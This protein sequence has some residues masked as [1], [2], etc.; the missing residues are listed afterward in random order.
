MRR[1]RRN[2]GGLPLKVTPV[3]KLPASLPTRQV[4]ERVVESAAAVRVVMRPRLPLP[5]P[6][7]KRVVEREGVNPVL[8]PPDRRAK[9]AKRDR[10]EV[11]HLLPDLDLGLRQ[12]EMKMASFHAM[13]LVAANAKRDRIALWTTVS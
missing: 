1:L 12:L 2:K 8:R 13:L 4:E 5:T 6:E 9:A 3:L 11:R 7:T 10:E